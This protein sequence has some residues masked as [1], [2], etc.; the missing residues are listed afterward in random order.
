MKRSKKPDSSLDRVAELC[1]ALPEAQQNVRG[2]HA[3][4]RV[5]GKVFA[6]YLNNHHGDGIVALC[7]KCSRGENVD[8]VARDPARFYLP[9]YI[10]KQGWVGFRLDVKSVPW[11][12]AQ[13]LIADSYRL[14]APKRLIALLPPVG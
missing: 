8:W 3:D 4:F 7:C 9:A 6:Y 10:G 12:Q 14:T 5:R 1:L 11:K 2:N 13:E